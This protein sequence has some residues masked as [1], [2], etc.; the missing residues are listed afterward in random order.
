MQADGPEGQISGEGEV[1]YPDGSV[2]TGQASRQ[3]WPTAKGASSTPDGSSYEGGWKAGVSEG[4]GSSALTQMVIVYEGGFQRR[5]DPTAKAT[6]TYADGYSYGGGWT[7]GPGA[8]A[9][10]RP[11]Y[12]R[13]ARST[14]GNSLKDLRQGSATNL[15]TPMGSATRASGREGRDEQLGQLRRPIPTADSYAGHVPGRETAGGSAR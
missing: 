10:A 4:A 8:M 11:T 6:M 15:S 5:Q 12:R 13:P 1:T 3:G 2:Y 7:L 14:E 9:R